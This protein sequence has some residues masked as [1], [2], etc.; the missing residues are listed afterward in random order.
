MSHREPTTKSGDYS[1]GKV[2]EFIGAFGRS[3]GTPTLLQL[4][5][6]NSLV[7]NRLV[8]CWRSGGTDYHFS[9]SEQQAYNLF[10][11][12][13]FIHPGLT[14]LAWDDLGPIAS[15]IR[16]TEETLLRCAQENK[17]G[18][19][20]TSFEYGWERRPTERNWHLV[21]IGG[22]SLEDVLNKYSKWA[23]FAGDFASEPFSKARMPA[24]YYL[25]NY[26]ALCGSDGEK[27]RKVQ[28][29]FLSALGK[30]YERTPASIVCEAAVTLC[31]A[32]GGRRAAMYP[33]HWGNEKSKNGH[34][35]SV[36]ISDEYTGNPFST[37]ISIRLSAEHQGS[38]K[39]GGGAGVCIYRKHDF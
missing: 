27:N 11:Q 29:D 23:P 31:C 36:E 30:Q 4:A 21:Y 37:N 24:G 5:H 3:G 20:T 15:E 8:S 14:R 18:D 22:F 10:G 7:M 33:A 34:Y 9:E 35:L 2:H 16:Y 12:E 26:R 28:D 17:E 6:E 38:G 1:L 32:Y 39:Y 25:I 19:Q 13:R